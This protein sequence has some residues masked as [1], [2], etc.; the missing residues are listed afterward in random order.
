MITRFGYR[1][2]IAIVLFVAYSIQYL[3]RVKTSV[4][5]PL[6]SQDIGLTTVDIGNGIF[7]MLMCYGPA[8]LASGFL[9]DRFGAKRIL[10]FSIVAWSVM[11]AWMGMIHSREEYMIR[12]AVFGALVGTEYVPSARILMRWFN[13]EGRARAQA[14]L[15]WAWILTPAWASIFATQLAHEAGS[16]RI[17]FFVTAALGV[18]P[19]VLIWLLVFDRPEQY[20]KITEAELDYA[21]ADEVTDGLLKQG[22]YGDSKAEIMQRQP[23]GFFDFFKQ[24]SY[25]AVIVC[26]IT[27]VIT[28]YGVLNWVPIYLSDVFHF[29]LKTMG[30][31]SALYFAAGAVGSFASSYLSDRVFQGN[32]RVMILTSFI[33]LIPFI[34]LLSTLRI[35]DPVFLALALCGMGFFGNMG[36]GPLTSV[37][38]E[39]FSP[40]VYGKA[41][42]FVNAASYMVT[43]FS[44]KIFSSLIIETQAGKDFT[45]GWYFIIF[46]VAIGVVAAT[47]IRTR[48]EGVP[49]VLVEAT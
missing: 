24:R 10:L 14:L 34:A 7:L 26:N 25:F 23:I 12:M 47:F 45:Q 49:L 38:A 35:G 16:W 29:N 13:K 22:H 48:L 11:T 27:L 9:A 15:S 2:V 4:L 33:G 30:L 1:W 21:Y 31:W 19:L 44:A 43:G 37:P 6:I 46:C 41:M 32:R 40:E 20:R 3:D 39:L 5:N 36:W 17:V 28:L 8:Q 42:G 18:V